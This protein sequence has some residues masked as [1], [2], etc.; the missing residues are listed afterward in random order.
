[1]I[2]ENGKIAPA[3]WVP[4]TRAGCDFGAV[5]TANTVLENTAI[6]IPTVFGAEL[7]RGRRGRRRIP[8]QAFADFV[9]IGVHCAAGIAAVLDGEQRQARPAARRAGR[10]QRL[11]RPLRR[12][13][14]QPADQPERPDDRPQRQRHPGR[15]RPRRLPRLRRDGGDG[16]AVV[17]RADAGG[18]HPVTYA[19]ISDAHDGHGTCGQHPLRLRAGRGRLRAAARTTTTWRSRSSST[20]SPPTASTSRTRCSSSP[21]TK[22]TTSSATRPTPAGCDGVTTPCTYNRVGEINAD[23]RADDLHPVR[24]HDAVLG[25]LRRRADRLRQRHSRQPSDQT[26]RRPQPG[27]GDGRARTG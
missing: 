2:N 7:A 21:S 23:L 24:R 5:A 17:R 1:M 8:A 13:V 27:T 26:T 15:H 9:G 4:Y 20:A 6:D 18:R 3:P 19:Y 14:R 25:A 22:A 12:Q 16:L 10:L 11:Q